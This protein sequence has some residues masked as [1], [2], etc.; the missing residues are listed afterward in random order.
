[1]QGTEDLVRYCHRNDFRLFSVLTCVKEAGL[2]SRLFCCTQDAHPA[3]E[4][5][6]PVAGDEI[7]AGF[8]FPGGLQAT[9]TS[10][11]KL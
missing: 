1:M 2:K 10:R 7:F 5:I 11:A 9:F 4:N 3:T 6:G 8:A